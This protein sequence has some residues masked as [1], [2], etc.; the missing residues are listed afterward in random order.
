MLVQ[1][2]PQATLVLSLWVSCPSDSGGSSRGLQT[3]M[4]LSAEAVGQAEVREHWAPSTPSSQTHGLCH[5][6]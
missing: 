4:V 2:C 1:V 5:L 6:A 3:T